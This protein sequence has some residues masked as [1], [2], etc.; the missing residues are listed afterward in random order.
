MRIRDLMVILITGMA[1]RALVEVVGNNALPSD[2]YYLSLVAQLAMYFG[3]AVVLQ[4]HVRPRRVLDEIDLA[5][6]FPVAF[7]VVLL[8][9]VLLIGTVLYTSLTSEPV[10]PGVGEAAKGAGEAINR[11]YPLLSMRVLTFVLVN[12]LVAGL[13]EEIFFRKFLLAT[14]LGRMGMMPGLL[15]SSGLFALFHLP[16]Q[17]G[18]AFV[19]SMLAGLIFLRQQRLGA[20]WIFHGTFNFLAFVWEYYLFRL[21]FGGLLYLPRAGLL[22]GLLL[23]AAILGGWGW[24]TLMKSTSRRS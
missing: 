4:M 15:C 20:C 22:T 8:A 7:Q 13:V 10:T 21:N 3:V 14:L 2:H 5:V 6:S 16:G 24:V 9:V 23:T 18:G 19:F 1:L 12:S 17:W 11:T